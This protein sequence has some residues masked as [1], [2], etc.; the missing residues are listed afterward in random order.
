VVDKG[1]EVGESRSDLKGKI[2][3]AHEVDEL[4]RVEVLAE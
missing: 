4:V 2:N 1:G 3:T